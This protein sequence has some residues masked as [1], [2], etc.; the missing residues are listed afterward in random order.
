MGIEE[1]EV[2]ENAQIEL[3][4]VASHIMNVC[5]K[6]DDSITSLERSKMTSEVDAGI[7]QW[8]EVEHKDK[9]QPPSWIVW[10]SYNLNGTRWQYTTV[11]YLADSYIHAYTTDML[12]KLNV[13]IANKYGYTLQQFCIQRMILKNLD[14]VHDTPSV[15]VSTNH[16]V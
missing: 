11:S 13:T 9:E 2:S 7:A 16:I 3:A 8:I 12:T 1:D 14:F 5:C 4:T 15:M 6:F 10:E